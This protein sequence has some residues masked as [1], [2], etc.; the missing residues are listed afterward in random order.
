MSISERILGRSA[1]PGGKPHIDAVMPACALPGGEI[2]IHGSRLKPPEWQQPTVRFGETSAPVLLASDQVVIAKVPDTPEARVQVAT[3]G[4]RSNAFPVSIGQL[5]TDEVHPVANPA[6]DRAGN[7]YATFSGNR[8]QK[9]A[10]SVYK[11]D[12]DQTV[13][14]FMTDVMNATGLAFDRAGNLFVSSRHEGIIYRVTPVGAAKIFAESMGVATGLA[15]DREGNL[16]VGDRSGTIFKLDPAGQT[17]VFATLEP[18]V[19]AYHLAFGSDGDLFVTGPTTSSYDAIYRVDPHGQVTEFYRGLGRPQGIAFDA[20]GNLFVAASW[21]GRRGIVRVTPDRRASLAVSGQ[22]IVGLAFAPGK[23]MVVTTTD[24]LYAL[25][26][27]VEG[28]PL[29]G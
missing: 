25:N 10:V 13:R 24:A 23:S 17:F 9:V 29:F 16:Y 8:G 21:E 22:Q 2:R 20:Q 12:A 26:V 28:S 3:N 7:I 18:S 11:V 19:S 14:P 27:G 5:I 4:D 15:F 6:L 1:A